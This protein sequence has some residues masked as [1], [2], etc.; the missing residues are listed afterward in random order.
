MGNIN[1]SETKPTPIIDTT[2]VINGL[3]SSTSEE[4]DALFEIAKHE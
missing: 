2:N 4:R 3:P 1:S